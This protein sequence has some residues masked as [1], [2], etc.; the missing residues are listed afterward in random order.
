MKFKSI[1]ALIFLFGI[2]IHGEAQIWKK[3]KNAAQRGVERTIENRTE[4]EVSATTDGAIDTVLDGGKN[5]SSS[6]KVEK[7]SP[8][9]QV[10]SS[11]DQRNNVMKELM[12]QGSFSTN[13]ILFAT[14][15]DKIQSSS[16]SILDEVGNFMITADDD[17]EAPKSLTIIGHTDSD[18]N[19]K[20]NQQLSKERAIAIKRYLISEHGIKESQL[21]VVG[22]GATEPIAVNKTAAG[23]AQNRRIEFKLNKYN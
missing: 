14:G 21:S 7:R 23:K 19:A 8:E 5:K 20:E 18:G 4:R 22:K 17:W 2:I 6:N 3:V 15:S 1:L 13:K 10:Q 11:T 12:E 9:R 16:N